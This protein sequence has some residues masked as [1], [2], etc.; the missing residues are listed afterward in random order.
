MRDR[1]EMDRRETATAI[2][3][4]AGRACCAVTNTDQEHQRGTT[5]QQRGKTAHDVRY[6]HYNCSYIYTIIV[7]QRLSYQAV[8]Q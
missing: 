4:V 1:T 2:V 5:T 6:P 8:S 7:S 3:D